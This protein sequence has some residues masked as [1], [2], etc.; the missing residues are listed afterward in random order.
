M[1]P[2]DYQSMIEKNS[3]RQTKQGCFIRTL[4]YLYVGDIT[5]Y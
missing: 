2:H 3:I 4:D 5:I 1:Q